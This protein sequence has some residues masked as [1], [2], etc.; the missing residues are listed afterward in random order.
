[1]LHIDENL[2]HNE[3]ETIR[4]DILKKSGV[5]VADFREQ[6][7]HVLMIEYDPDEITAVEFVNVAKE[8]GF[9]AELIGL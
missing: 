6:K 7:P 9:H 1:M 4:A 3:L 2:T 8:S 5:L